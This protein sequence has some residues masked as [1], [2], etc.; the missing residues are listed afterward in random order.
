MVLLS[1]LLCT[2]IAAAVTAATVPVYQSTVRF[3]VFAPTAT[4]Q[5][6]LQA[7]EL[8]RLR[9]VGYASLLTSES[10]V[11]QI[12]KASGVDE[13]V[14]DLQDM[15]RANGD[16]ETL[17]LT[18]DVRA[19]D[20][21]DASA[22]ASSI[23][24]NFNRLVN[25]LEDSGSPDADTRL[26]VV[27]GPTSD[28]NPV[29]P[30]ETLN[31]GLGLLIG[32]ALGVGLVILRARGDEAVYSADELEA[33]SGLKLLGTVPAVQ[34]AERTPIS[35]AARRSIHF[36]ALRNLRTTLHFRSDSEALRTIAVTSTSVGDGAST[37]AFSLAAACAEAGHRTLLVETDLR[38]P[39][40]SRM[41]ETGEERGLSDVLGGDAD[42]RGVVTPS[43]QDGLWLLTAGSASERAPELLGSA[44][45][46]LALDEAK[47]LFDIVIL[48]TAPLLPF[49]DSRTI[50]ALAD[51]VITVARYGRSNPAALKA[52]A[53][54]LHLVDATV[55]GV[56]F[57]AVPAGRHVVR[58]G[59]SASS[60][61]RHGI[62]SRNAAEPALQDDR[63][64]HQLDRR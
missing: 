48:D 64:D 30:R 43:A 19:T 52:A 46:K 54:T 62:D 61:G 57:N 56:V 26:N 49:A 44:E 38:D 1:V 6:A 28:D 11:E 35:A 25:D 37:V 12:G 15:I 21:E 14:E 18:V 27:A 17:I 39:Q 7:D 5:T 58:P 20:Q 41:L 22:I 40:L 45:M 55:L 63:P 29:S 23:A 9:I 10:I 33:V 47:D 2:G 31:Y 8:A 53:E 34:Q 32:L 16:A 4:G 51:G 42:L 36:E 3:Y 59:R 13:S 24:T 50:C 60:P